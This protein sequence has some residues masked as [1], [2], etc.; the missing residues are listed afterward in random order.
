MLFRSGDLRAQRRV[1]GDTHRTLDLG[2]DGEVGEGDA[3]INEEGARGKVRFEG[4]QGADL[5]TVEGNVVGLHVRG[6]LAGDKAQ[7][8]AGER[9]DLALGERDPLVDESGV[10]GIRAHEVGVGREGSDYPE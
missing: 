2:R 3:F 8:A 4:L 7:D 6:D 10:L 5:T 9:A 1:D